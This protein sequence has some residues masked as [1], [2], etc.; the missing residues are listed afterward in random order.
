VRAGEPDAGEAPTRR[1]GAAMCSGVM[2]AILVAAGFG[3]FGLL[4]PGGKEGWKAPGTLVVEKE[5]GTRYVYIPTDG[6]LHPVLNYAS[7]R[8]I[9]NTPDITVKDFSRRSLPAAP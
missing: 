6:A 5:T 1:I 2:V 8:L 3:I 4:R 7:A 9:L